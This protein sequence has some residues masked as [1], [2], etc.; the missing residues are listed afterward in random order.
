LIIS[1]A[2]NSLKPRI[3]KIMSDIIYYLDVNKFTRKEFFASRYADQQQNTYSVDI[4]MYS[5]ADYKAKGQQ[6]QQEVSMKFEES[7]EIKEDEI[8]L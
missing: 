5:K 6:Q 7:S 2:F 4:K 1:A 8:E 3:A